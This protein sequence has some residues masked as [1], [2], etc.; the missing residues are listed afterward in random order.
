MIYT[1]KVWHIIKTIS[2]CSVWKQKKL[3][4]NIILT[5]NHTWHITKGG[6]NKLFSTS[7]NW[8]T[9]PFCHMICFG[10][11]S[12]EMLRF[13]VQ[14]F[15]NPPLCSS[16]FCTEYWQK[17]CKCEAWRVVTAASPPASC[18][19]SDYRTRSRPPLFSSWQPP[20]EPHQAK[21]GQ[22]KRKS[23]LAFWFLQCM[24]QGR[25]IHLCIPMN[26]K[27]YI[28]SYRDILTFICF[29]LHCQMFFLKKMAFLH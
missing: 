13:M 3:F 12:N 25:C 27:K 5:L 28:K 16:T 11:H 7:H 4:D 9:T 14:V 29:W 1:W 20:A 8:G 23:L 24:L 6:W 2:L 21:T 26:C 17:N 18:R 19:T 15:Q 22:R 10:M